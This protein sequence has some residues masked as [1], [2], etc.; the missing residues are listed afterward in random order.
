MAHR[1]VRMPPLLLCPL[2]I[3]CPLQRIFSQTNRLLMSP[4]HL[5]VC[6]RRLDMALGLIQEHVIKGCCIFR[7]P[8]TCFERLSRSELWKGRKDAQYCLCYVLTKYLYIKRRRQSDV[9]GTQIKVLLYLCIRGTT[10]QSAVMPLFP[11]VRPCNMC[12]A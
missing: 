11:R 4:S 9:P 1:R 8:G 6:S 3:W 5:S 10:R 2:W 7:L 12:S